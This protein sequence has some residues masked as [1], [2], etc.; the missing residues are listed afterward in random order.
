M[1]EFPLEAAFDWTFRERRWAHAP[2]GHAQRVAD[3]L[4]FSPE[5]KQLL[6]KIGVLNT[7]IKNLLNWR[8]QQSQ[9][10]W[11]VK[12]ALSEPGTLQLTAE[13][14]HA[15]DVEAAKIRAMTG[16][17]DVMIGEAEY[18]QLRILLQEFIPHF[19]SRIFEHSK[20]IQLGL[21]YSDPAV[22]SWIEEY[23]EWWELETVQQNLRDNIGEIDKG[24]LRDIIARM[25]LFAQY[26]LFF[27]D[28]ESR[29]LLP[30]VDGEFMQSVFQEINNLCLKVRWSKGI[31]ASASTW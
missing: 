11:N 22:L 15:P 27:S 10:I 17:L 19:F 24:L 13:Q 26:R 14:V 4:S 9:Y 5:F 28:I 1:A 29:Q 12:F 6:W 30:E 2:T 8:A 20:S 3:A 25:K 31:S 18:R 16:A 21:D 23:R 7:Q